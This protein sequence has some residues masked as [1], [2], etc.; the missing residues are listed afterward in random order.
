MKACRRMA[1]QYD[2]REKERQRILRLHREW[3]ALEAA[4]KEKHLGK[5][6]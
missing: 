1:A 6:I 2:C 3:M 5:P 4:I